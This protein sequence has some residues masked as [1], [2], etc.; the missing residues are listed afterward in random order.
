MGEFKRHREGK[1]RY[2]RGMART[3]QGAG[4]DESAGGT[5]F[6]AVWC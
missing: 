3:V 1:W 4:K 6:E 5:D 2:K